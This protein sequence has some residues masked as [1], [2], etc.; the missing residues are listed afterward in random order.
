MS[1]NKL[2][3]FQYS[4]SVMSRRQRIIEQI[5]NIHLFLFF[6]KKIMVYI[7]IHCYLLMVAILSYKTAN[8]VM[9]I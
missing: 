5:Y 8:F 7:Y 2:Y 4:M 9:S 6:Y 3:C 1:V